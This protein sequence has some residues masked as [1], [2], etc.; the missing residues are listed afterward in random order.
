MTQSSDTAHHDARHDR[1]MLGIALMLGFCVSAPLGDAFAKLLSDMPVLLLVWARFAGQILL[2]LP[3]ALRARGQIWP[4]GR[5]RKLV[6]LRAVMHICG[7]L[8]MFTALRFLPLAEAVAIAFVMPFVLLLFGKLFLGEEVGPRRLIACAVGFAGTLMV[9]QPSFMQVGLPALLPLGVA[10]FFALFMLTTRAVAHDI[11]P[12]ALQVS[13]GVMATVLLLPLLV[14][15]WASGLPGLGLRLP[16]GH[17]WALLIGLCVI[18]SAS[19]LLMGWSLRFASTTTVGPM[20][21]LE[22]PFSTL[23]GWLIFSHLPNGLAAL[24]IGVT[25][26]AGLYVILREQKMARR[27]AAAA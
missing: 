1:P 5:V 9:I 18:G 27:R 6:A 7:I 2:M 8:C 17:E 21:Y 4:R 14:I 13:G 25:I 11:D 23:I 24:G 10:V 3:F 16:E 19:H 15:G 12:F 20:Q 22:I 26:G